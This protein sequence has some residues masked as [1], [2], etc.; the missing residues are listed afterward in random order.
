MQLERIKSE[1][2]QTTN[3]NQFSK[4][5]A[6]FHTNGASS[7]A[8]ARSEYLPHIRGNMAIEDDL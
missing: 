4:L 2:A 8:D 3:N 6:E 7:V 1:F 5:R